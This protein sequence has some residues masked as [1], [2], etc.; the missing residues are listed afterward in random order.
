MCSEHQN[1]TF[2]GIYDVLPNI[3]IRSQWQFCTVEMFTRL[4]VWFQDFRSFSWCGES[5]PCLRKH[6]SLF[7]FSKCRHLFLHVRFHPDCD[8]KRL[9]SRSF[10]YFSSA[11]VAWWL[12]CQFLWS[13]DVFVWKEVDCFTI[14]R[15]QESKQIYFLLQSRYNRCFFVH[16][17]QLQIF[18]MQTRWAQMIYI[19]PPAIPLIS[20]E[21]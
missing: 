10:L 13:L 3:C 15:L 20:P 19:F 5:T 2:P 16:Y 6:R 17:T 12:P 21:K 18:S 14:F 8:C 11:L 9:Q 1:A 4:S 7:F